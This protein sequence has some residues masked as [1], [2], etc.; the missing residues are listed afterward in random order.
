MVQSILQK[1]KSL[2]LIYVR[3]FV[4]RKTNIDTH[5]IASAFISYSASAAQCD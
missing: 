5:S 2:Y 1:N 3:L 4:D